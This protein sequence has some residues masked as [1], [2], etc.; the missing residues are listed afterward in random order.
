[1]RDIDA[2]SCEFAGSQVRRY[3]AQGLSRCGA[4][5]TGGADVPWWVVPTYAELSRSRSSELRGPSEASAMMERRKKKTMMMKRER[6]RRER[7]KGQ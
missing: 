3:A 4:C 7:E 6:C 5:L 2:V 1:M